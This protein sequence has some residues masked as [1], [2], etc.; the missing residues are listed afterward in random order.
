MA[1]RILLGLAA[2]LSIAAVL[3]VTIGPVLIER[4]LNQREQIALPE[5]SPEAQ[6]LHDRLFIADMHGDTLLWR[7]DLLDEGNRGHMD[8][9]R[10]EAG[11]VALQVFSSVTKSPA[12]LNY[13]SNPSDSDRIWLVAI[14]QLQPIRTWN[15]LAERSL[16]HATKLERAET[17]SGGRLRIVRTASDLDRLLTDRAAGAQVTGGLLSVEGLHNLEGDFDNLDRLY[18]AGFR[19]ASPTHFFDNELGGSMHGEEKGGLTDFG[20]RVIRAMEE[21]G[22]IVD[23][24]H[25]SPAMVEDILAMARRPVVSSHGGVQ[26]ICD[27]NR[28]LSDTQ[29][30]AIADNGGVIGI[31]YWDGAICS[32]DPERVVDSIL[33]VRALAGVEH[34]GLGSDYDGS[35]TVGFDT[36]EIAVITQLLLDRGVPEQEI[37]LIMGGNVLRLLREG[38]PRN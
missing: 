23:I 20:R 1:R 4:S 10:L 36:S 30:R 33:H 5:I 9:P 16:W 31:G 28:N 7:R 18:E 3:S 38:L 21:R 14:S 22:M 27:V 25:A 6:A 26:A 8:L 17:R 35:T 37:A 32:F 12:G 2:L 13:D 11:N 29:I 24:A 15:S 34:V 19:M